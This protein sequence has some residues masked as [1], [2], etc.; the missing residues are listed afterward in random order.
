MSEVVKDIG[1]VW[2]RIFDHKGFLSGEIAFML[3]EFQTKRNDK[4][5]DSLFNV[6]ENITEIKDTGIDN[7]VQLQDHV[8]NIYEQLDE[9]LNECN[10]FT[11]LE[12]TIKTDTTI[13]DIQFKRKLAWEEFMETIYSEIDSNFK[14]KELDIAQLFED[15]EKKLFI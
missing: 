13:E 12:E 4:E 11:N 9:A 8:E 3:R 10:R 1:K 6:I 5:V 14:E 15:I 2:D 7:L